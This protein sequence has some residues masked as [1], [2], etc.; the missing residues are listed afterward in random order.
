MFG[1]LA[2]GDFIALW[3]AA[4]VLMQAAIDEGFE[5]QDVPDLTLP[6]PKSI[7]TVH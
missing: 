7:D 2:F 6:D 1:P 5:P 3:H 4:D